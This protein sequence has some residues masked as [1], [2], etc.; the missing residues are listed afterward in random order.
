M[1]GTGSRVGRLA[2]PLR[3]LF[4]RFA[5]LLLVGASVSLMGLTRVN[6]APLER[7][8]AV[9]TDIAVP[10][11]DVISRPVAAAN[12]GFAEVGNLMNIYQENERLRTENDRLRSWQAE[13]RQLAQEN[14]AF[15]A[16]LR[17]QPEPGLT[18][19]SARVVGD[20][21]G[22]FVRA[23]LLNAGSQDGV[24][25]GEAA[26]NADGLI[27]RVVEAGKRS[28]RILLLTD[29]NSRV[30]V[31]VENTRYRGILEG[32]NS[33]TLVLEFVASG[34]GV[35]VGDRIMT[36]GHGGVFPAGIP[37]GM[38]SGLEDDAT[39]VAPLVDF[40]TLEFVRVLRFDFPGLDPAPGE[41]G[42]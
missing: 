7:A 32:D 19:V 17:A 16:L 39:Q 5:F 29:L 2:V 8:R 28:S 24:R 31:V 42:D 34:A 11:L 21:G 37:V 41:P 13:A 30:P 36:S 10:V 20:S 35:R 25:K 1:K 27:G 14:A 6:Y 9:I 26:V 22:P 18:F 38:V 3:V 23:L 4:N 33:D 12:R 15:R 40:R